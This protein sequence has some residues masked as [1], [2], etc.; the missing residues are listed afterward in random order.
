[1]LSRAGYLRCHLK[2]F[3]CKFELVV[4]A[5]LSGI[6]SGRQILCNRLL[7]NVATK[8]DDLK[9]CSRCSSSSPPQ[10]QIAKLLNV[11]FVCAVEAIFFNRPM[12]LPV[13]VAAAI[14]VSGVAIV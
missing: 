7:S 6:L 9:C 8:T 10:L 13:V 3:H 12:T 11:P 4:D 14:V 2:Y 1:M 5:Q